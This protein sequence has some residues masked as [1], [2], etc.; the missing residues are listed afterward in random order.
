MRHPASGADFIAEAV[1]QLLVAGGGFRKEFQGHRL[2]QHQIVSA[3]DFA[4]SAP[5]EQ[6]HNSVP[7]GQQGSGKE[8]A[9]ARETA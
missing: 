6:G 2:A 3:V 4:H 1:E 8:A 9:F 7:L 5:A